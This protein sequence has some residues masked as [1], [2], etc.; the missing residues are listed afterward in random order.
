MRIGILGTGPVGQALG[1][2]W[3]GLGHDVVLGSRRPDNDSAVAWAA[4]NGSRA[5]SGTFKTAAASADL[6]VNATAGQNSIAALTMAA[7]ELPGKVIL[8]VANALDFSHGFP[9]ALAVGPSDSLAEAIQRA[10]PDVRVVKAL[11]TMPVEIMVA[12]AAVAN[13]DHSVF[14]SG[15]DQEAKDLVIGLLNEMGWRGDRVFDLGNLASARGP[16]LLLPLWLMVMQRSGRRLVTFRV[17]TA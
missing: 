3:V 13:G 12:P 9:P 7:D 15:D 8:D 2:C 17:V 5:T 4:A 11:N 16:E 14:V 10:F 6:V 1:A